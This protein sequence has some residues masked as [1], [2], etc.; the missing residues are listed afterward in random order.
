MEYSRNPNNKKDSH[1]ST[2]IRLFDR[3]MGD[4]NFHYKNGDFSKL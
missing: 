1:K 4:L 2:N 3:E